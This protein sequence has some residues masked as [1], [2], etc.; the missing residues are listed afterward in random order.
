ML[1]PV[2]VGCV[3]AG[4]LAGLDYALHILQPSHDW[5]WHL[6]P[7]GLGWAAHHGSHVLA[8]QTGQ[9]SQDCQLHLS[10]HD[11]GCSTHH[12]SHVFGSQM[13]QPAQLVQLHLPV[14]PVH[15]F[16]W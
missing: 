6:S 13:W 10:T 2:A 15:G 7:H 1:F 5:N 4:A 14:V 9:P 8:P 12:G 16:G 3:A 11:L